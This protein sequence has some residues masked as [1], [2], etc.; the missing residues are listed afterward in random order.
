MLNK[1]FKKKLNFIF[2]MIINIIIK[3]DDLKLYDD[4]INETYERDIDIEKRLIYINNDIMASLLVNLNNRIKKLE[5]EN[6]MLKHN[7]DLLSKKCKIEHIIQSNDQDYIE[8]FN[9]K[10]LNNE[11]I[12][13]IKNNHFKYDCFLCRDKSIDKYNIR[14]NL[15]KHVIFNYY[16]N[17]KKIQSGYFMHMDCLQL[18]NDNKLTIYNSNILNTFINLESISDKI[19]NFDKILKN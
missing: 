11:V 8:Y 5:E 16:K 6:D 15:Y 2:F 4:I 19:L 12:E 18:F 9:M 13:Y 14:K 3:M 17:D 10:N 7:I 1:N